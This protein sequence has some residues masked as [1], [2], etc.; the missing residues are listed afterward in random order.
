MRFIPPK[1]EYA[2]LDLTAFVIAHRPSTIEMT[3]AEEFW[4]RNLL[5][6]DMM[7][8]AQVTFHGIPIYVVD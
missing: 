4:Y 2:L 5:N 7:A 3:L 1:E 6:P 8:P